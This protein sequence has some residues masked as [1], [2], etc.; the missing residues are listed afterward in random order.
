L[1]LDLRLIECK[2]AKAS[3]AHL[4]KAREQLESGLR[5][6]V[7]VFKPRMANTAEDDRPDQRYW[8]LQLYRLIASKAEIAERDQRR[9]LT[10]LERLAE[11]DYDVEWRA[12]A[13]TF[14]TDQPSDGLSETA[15]WTHAFDGNELGISPPTTI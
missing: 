10:S 6:M 2:L 7:S 15:I 5:Q 11:G 1:H 13:I 14:W 8:W 4:Q 12:A 9:V 3:D